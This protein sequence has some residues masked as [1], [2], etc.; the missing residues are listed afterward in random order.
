[1]SFDVFIFPGMSFSRIVG[2][3]CFCGFNSY[4]TCDKYH[5]I[6]SKV[7]VVLHRARSGLPLL[8]S[9]KCEV[10]MFP[11]E[12]KLLSRGKNLVRGKIGYT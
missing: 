7:M 11:V 9:A 5:V 3:D 8:P 10:V 6:L 4:E 1:M 2:N 12:Y